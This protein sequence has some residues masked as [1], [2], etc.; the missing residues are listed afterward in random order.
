MM[1]RPLHK[2][3]DLCVVPFT[4]SLSAEGN[5]LFVRILITFT[6]RMYGEVLA[7]TIHRRRLD[8]EVLLAPPGSSD[9][10]IERFGPHVLVQGADEAEPASTVLPDGVLCRMRILNTGSL[11]A[12]IELDGTASELHDVLFEDLFE[13]LEKAEALSNGD[14][15]RAEDR[16][17]EYHKGKATGKDG[18]E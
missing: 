6:P 16:R 18:G 1:R 7:L 8:F 5:A 12:T 15:A 4:R 10:E 2:V 3:D 11:D 14:G 13:V 17:P 9:G